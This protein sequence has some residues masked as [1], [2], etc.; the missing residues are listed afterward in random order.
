MPANGR[1]NLI[2]RLK[3]KLFDLILW[4]NN[5]T[6]YLYSDL[7]FLLLHLEPL[8]NVNKTYLSVTKTVSF[9]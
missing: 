8:N 5:K 4:N 6:P 9:G 7:M 1:W 2:R 3:V